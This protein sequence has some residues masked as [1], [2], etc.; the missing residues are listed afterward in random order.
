MLFRL[1]SGGEIMKRKRLAAILVFAGLFFIIG[2]ATTQELTTSVRSKVSSITSTVDPALVN[3][4]PA[5]KRE[6]FAKAEYDLNA[7]MEKVK[8]AELKNELA[9]AQKK[10]VSYAVDMADSFRKDAELD[11]DLVKIEAIIETGLGKKDDNVKTKANLQQKKLNQQSNRI[12]IKADIDNSK[13]KIDDLT[14]QI[15]KMEESVN[16]MKFDAGKA[17]PE[18]KKEENK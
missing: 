4:I 7:A 18:P 14:A 9:G 11:Y 10:Y 15:A 2:C 17:A 1:L 16:A 12:G 8:L 3:Q 13:R 6:G 5:D